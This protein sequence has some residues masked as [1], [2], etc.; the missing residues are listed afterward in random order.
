VVDRPLS[1]S[2]QLDMNIDSLFGRYADI[3][4]KQMDM[5]GGKNK[6]RVYKFVL[7]H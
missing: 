6:M 1:Q 2:N 3:I 4:K 7:Y 5:I